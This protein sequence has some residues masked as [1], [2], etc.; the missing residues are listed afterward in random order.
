M[1]VKQ[2]GWEVGITSDKGP[3]KKVNEDRAAFQHVKNNEGMEA[4]IALVAD[5][6]G[7]YQAGDLA[8]KIAV[9][10]IQEWWDQ[11]IKLILNEPFP[12]ILIAKEL[13]ERLH[14]INQL[15]LAIGKSEEMNLGTTISVLIFFEDRY[16][17]YHVGDSRIYRNHSKKRTE[18]ETMELRDGNS[19]F[20]RKF[21]QLT[22][23]HSWV[24]QQVKLGYLTK[25]EA[26]NHYKRNVLI[27][28]LGVVPGLVVFQRQGRFLPGDLFLLCSDGYHSMFSD[29]EIQEMI[30]AHH[31]MNLQ[32]VSQSFVHS[33]NQAGTIDNATV[34]LMKYHED[35]GSQKPR[36]KRKN[37]L[38]KR[39]RRLSKGV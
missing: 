19:L 5:G 4:T 3:V 39:T 30:R 29:R 37:F 17:V 34:L 27:Q 7:G 25:D 8:S 24:A 28:C 21:N 2:S 12:L 13:N 16:L 23:D 36:F 14:H 6:M 9:G 31:A 22:Q 32:Q 35:S 26:R 18:L 10:T 38:K 15:L 11:R 33:A 20:A 1:L